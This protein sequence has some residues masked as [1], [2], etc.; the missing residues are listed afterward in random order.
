MEKQE[1]LLDIEELINHLERKNVR[2]R[3]KEKAKDTL[4]KLGYFKLK[5]FSYIYRDENG[6]YFDNTYFE[7][8]VDNFYLDKKLRLEILSLIENIEIYLKTRLVKILGEKGAYTYLDF[9]SW[10]NRNAKEEDVRRISQKIVKK[11]DKIINKEYVFDKKV[12]SLYV[13]KYKK[14]VLPIWVIMETL[15]LGEITEILNVA[16]PKMFEIAYIDVY[17]NYEEFLSKLEVIKDVRNMAAHNNDVLTEEYSVGN[18]IDVIEIILH[19]CKTIDIDV[20]YSKIKEILLE[21][22]EKTYWFKN[23]SKEYIEDLIDRS[24]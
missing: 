4:S 15:T 5:E 16:Y 6:R 12:V 9:P 3:D 21:I 8:F 17:E 11:N 10:T 1:I 2:F 20:D 19:F 13:D 14:N 18:I 24:F 23:I 7:N 22:E